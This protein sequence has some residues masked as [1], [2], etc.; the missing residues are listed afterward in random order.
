VRKAILLA[1]GGVLLLAGC[2]PSSKETPGI[3]VEPKWKGPAYRLA[4]DT[5]APKPNPT[6]ITLPNIK[7]TANPEALERRVTLVLHYDSSEVKSDNLIINQVTLAPFDISGSEGTLSADTMTQ[8]DQGLS[9]LL[10]AYCMKPKV[11]VSVALAR[12]S[13]TPQADDA[14]INN[15]RLSDWQTIELPYKNLK[16]GCPAK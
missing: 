8:A 6:G 1:L 10:S 2:G 15:K 13:L 9:K 11:K 5:N 7:F 3:P 16:K 4:F 14:E 12:S